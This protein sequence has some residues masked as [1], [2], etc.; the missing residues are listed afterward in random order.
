MVPLGL[1]PAFSPTLQPW[2]NPKASH[3]ARS[4]VLDIQRSPK[5]PFTAVPDYSYLNGTLTTDSEVRSHALLTLHLTITVSLDL[6][7]LASP[8]A[9]CTSNRG[10]CWK[11]PLSYSL[12]HWPL[13]QPQ[14]SQRKALYHSSMPT[15]LPLTAVLGGKHSIRCLTHRESAHSMSW[16]MGLCMMGSLRMPLPPTHCPSLVQHPF[17]PERSSDLLPC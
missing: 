9:S 10:G 16:L 11:A 14:P 2:W 8:L 1:I 5:N 6:N 15:S 13:L 12:W 7:I 3:P 17:D 4:P